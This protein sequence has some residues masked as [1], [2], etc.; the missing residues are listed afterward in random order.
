MVSGIEVMRQS[1]HVLLVQKMVYVY[2][3]VLYLEQCT[4]FQ[5]KYVNIRFTLT[6]AALYA[7][8]I[9]LL[10]YPKWIYFVAQH[11]LPFLQYVTCNVGTSPFF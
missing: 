6:S 1:V 5:I 3:A 2:K 7:K 9:Y 4:F 8:K 11:F 10:L